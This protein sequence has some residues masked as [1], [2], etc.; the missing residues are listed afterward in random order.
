MISLIISYVFLLYPVGC[1]LALVGFI[2]FHFTIDRKNK[3]HTPTT[4]GEFFLV[5]LC[6]WLSVVGLTVVFIAYM[7]DRYDEQKKDRSVA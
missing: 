1:F 5:I 6:S 2:V 3:S 4:V 7:I